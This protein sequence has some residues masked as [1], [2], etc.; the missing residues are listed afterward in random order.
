[1]IEIVFGMMLFGFVKF[2][3]FLGYLFVLGLGSSKT[4]KNKYRRT[5]SIRILYWDYFNLDL[6]LIAL[7]QL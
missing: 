3:G 6:P 5:R 2:L 4:K 7:D 1:M